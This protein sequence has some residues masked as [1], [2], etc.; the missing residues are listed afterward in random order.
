MKNKFQLL[1][2]LLLGLTSFVYVFPFAFVDAAKL[3]SGVTINAP[4]TTETEKICNDT[5]DNDNDGKIDANDGDCAA[6]PAG[7]TA[8]TCGLQIVDGVPINYGQLTPA[9]DSTEQKVTIKNEG[10]SQT[11]AKIMIKG[12]DWIID[13]EADPALAF[14]SGPEITHV[15][16]AP[17]LDW[18]NKKP[19]SSAGWE[20][21]QIFGGQSIPVYF[22]LKV[23]IGTLSG[24]FHQDVTIDLLCGGNEFL[25]EDEAK[26][27]YNT[28][29]KT[30]NAPSPLPIP[31]P[32][33]NNTT[34]GMQIRAD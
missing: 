32:D 34:T 10:T 3:Q 5:I 17:N 6:A 4:A 22:Q 25:K 26:G 21:G 23:P 28:S 8:G 33:T 2:F 13:A 31:Y 27:D 15:T 14:I 30:P 29:A 20:L 7:P 16:I 19:L 18:S 12:G 11:P 1:I 24:S 9:Q